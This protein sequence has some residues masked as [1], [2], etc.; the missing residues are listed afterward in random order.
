M[1]AGSTKV[2]SF[3]EATAFAHTEPV[4][5]ELCQVGRGI[6]FSC[7][8]ALRKCVVICCR[9]SVFRNLYV[10]DNVASGAMKVQ[11]TSVPDGKQA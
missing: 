6:P 8:F 10:K 11:R 5:S 2:G 3:D 4:S 7:E 9:I 1:E